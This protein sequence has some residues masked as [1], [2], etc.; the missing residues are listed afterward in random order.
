MSRS[1]FSLARQTETIKP[2]VAHFGLYLGFKEN[3]EDLNLQKANYWIYPENSYDHDANVA[4]YLADP[5]AEF[6]VVYISFPSA[7]DS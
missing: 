5:S 3:Y 1:I 2:S 7:K 6:P 4:R